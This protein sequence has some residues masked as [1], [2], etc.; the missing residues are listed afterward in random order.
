MNPPPPD[1][2]VLDS[3][4]LEPSDDERD[5]RQNVYESL[6]RAPFITHPSS[7]RYHGKSSNIMFLQTIVDMKQK[8]TG[9][10]RPKSTEPALSGSI[11]A[12]SRRDEYGPVSLPPLHICYH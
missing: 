2:P 7:T 5:A 1:S 8:L 11:T 4:E 3:D 6:T 10:E 12:T 9:T